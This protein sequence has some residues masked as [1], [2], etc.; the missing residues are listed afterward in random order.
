M[1]DQQ[2]NFLQVLEK[3]LGVV[4]IALQK[5]ELDRETYDQ[6]M[7][8]HDFKMR[9]QQI[10]EMSLDFV[11]NKLLKKIQEEDLNAIQFYLK[12]KGKKR[13]Y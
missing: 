1:T 4:S 11:E 8:N 7:K 10:N 2:L 12:T 13:G 6:W 5:T 3:S 9:C